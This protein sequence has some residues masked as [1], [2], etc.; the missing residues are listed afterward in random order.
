[1]LLAEKMVVTTLVKSLAECTL[2]SVDLAWDVVN[3]CG[4]AYWTS[5]KLPVQNVCPF[6]YCDFLFRGDLLFF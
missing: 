3:C 1:M 5:L 4:P 2:G 6:D